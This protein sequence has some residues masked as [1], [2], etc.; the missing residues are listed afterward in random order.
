[1]TCCCITG[2][3]DEDSFGIKRCLGDDAWMLWEDAGLNDGDVP[4]MLPSLMDMGK[5]G[6]VPIS[7][8][9]LW[10]LVVD[11]TWCMKYSSPHR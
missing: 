4:S 10:G 6:G 3:G 5:S 8:I 1:M 2:G 11:V 9:W 7:G